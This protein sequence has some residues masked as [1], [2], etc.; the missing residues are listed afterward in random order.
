MVASTYASCG[1]TCTSSHTFCM[2]RRLSLHLLP[3]HQPSLHM[4]QPLRHQLPPYTQCSDACIFQCYPRSRISHVIPY[5]VLRARRGQSQISNFETT[6]RTPQ[7]STR[8]A[9]ATP[10]RLQ[11]IYVWAEPKV[12]QC[13]PHSRISHVIPKGCCVPGGA[14]LKYSSGVGVRSR[15]SNDACGG[16]E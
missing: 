7:P 4:L 11:H 8:F 14:C 1:P 13:Y 9:S 16:R 6:G 3:A 15:H 12:E 5:R 10:N 2:P